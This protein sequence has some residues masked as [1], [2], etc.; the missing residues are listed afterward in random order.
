[1]VTDLRAAIV[2]PIGRSAT[3]AT[4]GIRLIVTWAFSMSQH[5]RL[6]LS[7]AQFTLYLYV[8]RASGIAESKGQPH[9]RGPLGQRSIE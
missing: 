3:P 6:L 2:N 8:P 5:D 4:P 9:G 7:V 1:L